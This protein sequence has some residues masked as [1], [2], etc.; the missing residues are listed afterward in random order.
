MT[1]IDEMEQEARK[2]YRTSDAAVRRVV[3]AECHIVECSVI[4]AMI[5]RGMAT[6]DAKRATWKING[7]RASRAACEQLVKD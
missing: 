5:N 7:K 3:G 2:A 4:S 1:I 6:G